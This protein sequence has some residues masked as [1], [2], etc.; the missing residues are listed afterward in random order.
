MV[1][2]I[3]SGDISELLA[4]RSGRQGRDSYTSVA[5]RSHEWKGAKFHLALLV[6]E[7]GDVRWLGRAQGRKRVSD[8][9]RRVDISE[10]YEVGG[11]SLEQIRRLLPERHKQG[12]QYGILSEAVGEAVTRALLTFHPSE[13]DTI[14]RLGR[15]EFFRQEPGE[16]G[17]RLNEQRDATGL[18][19][20]IGEV[21]REALRDMSAPTPAQPSFLAGLSNR[22]ASEENL[23]NYDI[24]RFPGMTEVGSA[25]VDWRIFQSNNRRM[26]IMNAN[27]EPL[28]T[29]LGTDVIYYNEFRQSFVLLQYKRLVRE[30]GQTKGAWYR[31]DKNI[32]AELERMAK[33]DELCGNVADGEFRLHGKACWVKLCDSDARVENSQDLVKGMYLAR[34]YFEELLATLKGPRKG[35]R[36][37]YDNVPRHINN[38]TFIQL[39]KDGWIGTRGTATRQLEDIVREVLQNRR[40]LVLGASMP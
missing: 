40:V 26:F 36:L 8:R 18:L 25:H 17:R 22:S 5:W 3:D 34:E 20:E 38:T 35:P 29:T 7:E 15:Q 9:E 14:R 27:M 32:W 33:V 1:A 13:S 19:L 4:F 37:G 10:I 16:R 39:V 31:P 21:G 2:V 6:D 28:E 11:P 12:L 24:G 30:S 23:I